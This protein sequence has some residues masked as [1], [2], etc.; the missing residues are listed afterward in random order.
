MIN[1]HQLE[2]TEIDNFVPYLVYFSSKNKL[3][4]I[5]AFACEASRC[6]IT[7]VHSINEI[8]PMLKERSP[9][10]VILDEKD[11]LVTPL[12]EGM[13]KIGK[14]N[15]VPLL[16]L[17]KKPNDLQEILEKGY[18]GWIEYL[19]DGFSPEFL[20]SK[21]LIYL[22]IYEMSC[23]EKGYDI[24]SL[25]VI[26]KKAELLEKLNDAQNLAMLGRLASGVAHDFNN[27]LGGILGYAEMTRRKYGAASPEIDRY[28][29]SIV[30]FT[31]R[32]SE[33]TKEILNFARPT[34]EGNHIF[35]VHEVLL[36]VMDLLKHLIDKKCQI[37]KEM[38]ATSCHNYGSV[39]LLQNALI[40]LA[41]NACDAMENGG[42][43]KFR[44]ENKNLDEIDLSSIGLDIDPGLYLILSVEDTGHGMSEE[45][46]A[47][48]FDPF[49]TTQKRGKGTGL[50]LPSVKRAVDEL[51]GAL[52]VESKVGRG[53]CFDMFL[54]VTSAEHDVGR[55]SQETPIIKGKGT[56]LVVDD[57]EAL[58]DILKEMLTDVGYLIHTASDGQEAI[59][60]F[61]RHHKEIDLVIVDFNLPKKS[62]KDC[63]LAFKEEKP[64]IKG[65]LST[66][67]SLDEQTE[68]AM[69]QGMSAFIQKP[70]EI[71]ELLKVIQTILEA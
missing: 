56:I 22:K 9:A 2:H 15:K 63:F 4:S 16:I 70:F 14:A 38:F 52:K 55:S 42:I 37:K 53:T 20:R 64:E 23:R 13:I 51:N 34:K 66:G 25:D 24:E 40:N 19:A 44:T 1:S 6:K 47:K 57:E 11:T 43:L 50:G 65:I 48:I 3:S 32:A 45:T 71:N 39:S 12:C 49:F 18:T 30:N 26:P 61:K 68:E 28:S 17:N 67:F 59:E 27:I 54:P 10:V 62:G 69:E 29:K 8:L 41:L 35:D 5:L 31:K 7:Q 36:E 33:L 21:I 58:R 60:Y 46:L